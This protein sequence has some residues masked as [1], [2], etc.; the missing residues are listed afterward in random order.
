MVVVIATQVRAEADN[1]MRSGQA[2][3]HG[4]EMFKAAIAKNARTV[5]SRKVRTGIEVNKRIVVPVSQM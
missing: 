3:G 5:N 4:M 2:F 1:L